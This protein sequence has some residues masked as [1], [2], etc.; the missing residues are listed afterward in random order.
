MADDNAIPDVAAGKRR[1]I[2]I[3]WI[4]PIVAAAIA[5]YLAFITISEKGPEISIS[6]ETADGLEE[7]KTKVKFRNVDVGQVDSVTINEDLSGVVATASLRK[8]AAPF[9]T[10]NT[11]FWVVR[12]RLGV[13]EVS[14]LGTLVSGAYIEMDPSSEGASQRDFVGLETPPLVRSDDEGTRFDLIAPRLGSFSHGSPVYY[15]GFEAGR[16]VGFELAKDNRSVEVRI[17]I[18]A[19]YDTLVRKNSRFWNVSGIEVALD[20]DGMSV[21]TESLVS[22]IA[23]GIAFDTPRTL[24]ASPAAEEN[25]LFALYESLEDVEEST[26]V[27]RERLIA[28]FEGSVRGLSVGAPVEVRGARVGSVVDVNVEFNRE[29]LELRAP[30]LIELEAGR[31]STIGEEP[32]NTEAFLKAMIDKGFRAQLKSG[33]LITG[34]LLV[35]LD[36]YPDTP[37]NLVG[38]DDRYLEIPTIPSDLEEITASV[39]G[40][41]DT[42]ASLPLRELIED[43]RTTVQSANSVISS[44]ELRRSLASLDR[45]LAQMDDILGVVD[46]EAEP[47]LESLRKTSD[48]AGAAAVQAEKT[49][50]SADS[51]IGENSQLRYDLAEMLAQLAEAAR[52]IRVLA[53]YLEAHPEALISGKRGDQ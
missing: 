37:V 47:L 51:M 19:P 39:S 31:I 21:K 52:S 24:E 27:E 26:Y 11:R 32:E 45:S 4:V 15:R 1:G 48:A 38:E 13:G 41:L 10:E 46:E 34:Q 40:V 16:V 43:M 35:A 36:F 14:G 42:L 3:V 2:S 8:G 5:G 49:L 9:L 28:Y 53:E 18:D 33:S 23:G 44:P 17:F 22:L 6:F 50:A 12:P 30:V 20:A 29:T 7:G 25:D